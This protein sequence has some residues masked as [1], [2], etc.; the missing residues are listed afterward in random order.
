MSHFSSVSAVSIEATTYRATSP[1]TIPEH[2]PC[3]TGGVLTV[4]DSSFTTKVLVHSGPTATKRCTLVALLDT[5]SPQSFITATAVEQ[6]KASSS[7]S[8]QCIRHA[9]PRS[10]GGFGTA[11]PL[12]TSDSIRLSI[13]FMRSDSNTKTPTAALAVWACIV[14]AGTMQHSILLGRDS[15][16]RFGQRSY[17][18]LP[19]QP[20]LPHHNPPPTQG[21]LTLHHHGPSGTSAFIPDD[22]YTDDV[23]HLRFAG[24]KTVSLSPTP[25]LVKV[26]L[27]R[28]SGAPA[29]TGN[30][31]VNMDPREDPL[32][33]TAIFVS[34][35]YQT[36]PLSGS[37]DLEPGDLL[38]TSSSPLVQVPLATLEHP[39]LDPTPI[40][41]VHALHDNIPVANEGPPSADPPPPPKSPCP[42][43]L[44][45]LDTDQRTRFL[46]LWDRLP[47]H[48]RDV[49]FDL[50]GSGWSP[51]VIDA[52]GDV[53]CEYQDVFSSSKTDFGSCSL[54]PF[55]ITVPP[56]S[57]PVTSRPYRIN[58]PILAKKADAVLDQYLAAGLIQHST[59][60]YSSPMV[61]IPKKD[62]GV[63]ITINYKKLNAISS[64]GQL[65]IPRVDQVLDSLGK[66]RIFSLFDLTS[67]FHQITIDEATIPLTAFC[68]PT[69]LFEW[70][71]M[72]QGSSASPGWFVKVINEVIK[73]LERVAAYLD[74]IIVFDPDPTAHV[75][76]MRALFER[77]RKHHLKLSPAK[78]KIGATTADFLGHTITAGGFSP[79]A[80]KVAALTK[81]PIPKNKKQVRSLIGAI[82]YYGK[83]LEN[84]SPRIRR[85]TALLKKDATF[86]FTPDMVTTVRD[87][88][89]ELSKPPIL[90]YPD[91]DAVADNSRPFRLYCDA[92]LDGFGATLEQE[93]P[94]GSVRPILYIS[95]ATLDSERSWTPLDLEAG[96]IVWAI[97]RLRGHLWSTKFRVYS[98]HKALEN[99]AKVGEHNARV[100]RWLEFLSA[101]DYTLEYRKGTANGNADFLSRLPLPATEADRTGRN[102]LTGPDTV[103][104]YLIRPCGFSPCEP[105]TPGIGLGGL[106]SPPS[107]PI[108][109][110]QALRFT[111]DDFGDFRLLGPRI[112]HPDPFSAPNIFVGPI[113]THNAIDEPLASPEKAAVD[114]GAPPGYASKPPVV[115]PP[116]TIVATVPAPSDLI[117]SR[118]RHRAAA[119]AGTPLATADYGF[120]R[121]PK[122]AE[123]R[124]PTSA[125][126]TPSPSSTAQPRLLQPPTP[127]AAA[128]PQAAQPAP[129]V[130]TH[131]RSTPS[132]A[133]SPPIPSTPTPPLPEPVVEPDDDPHLLARVER[134]TYKDWAREQRAEPLCSA[135]IR[136]LSLDSPS[137]PPPD[138]LDFIPLVRRPQLSDVL[139]LGA[140]SKLHRTDDN[141]ALLVLQPPNHP[142]GNNPPSSALP[143]PRVYVPMLMRPWV[144]QTCHATTSLHLGVT[145][146]V[147]MLARFYWWVGMDASARWW[148]RRCLTCQA[149][150]TSRQTIRWPILSLPLPNGPGIA[151]SV[152]Y[153]GP[154][155]LTPRGNVHILLF[156]DRF[157]RR[158]D[159]FPVS[160]AQFTAAGTADIFI[161][162]YITLWGCPVTLLSDN[163]LQFT[164]KLSRIVYERLGVRKINT[165]SYHPCTN[166]GVERVNHVLAQMLSMI[167]NEQQTDWD[168]LLPHVSSAY[169]NSVNAATGLAPNE[170]HI[171]RLPRLPLSVFE[172]DNIGGHQSLDRDHLA[173][174]NL[175]TD[176][177][178]RAYSLV[179]ELYSITTSRL[180][181]RN[182]P[183][184]AALLASPPFT[185]GGWA[186]VYNS[187]S[188]IRQ[189]V[190]KD[191]DATVLK[192]KLSLNWNGPF[193]ILA[194]GPAAACDTPDNRPLHDKL[195]FLDLPSDLPG[196]DSKPRVS[197][198]RCKP[199]RN[200]DD[201]TDIPHYLPAGLTTYVLTASANKSP[202]YHVTLDDVSPPPERLEV[203]KITGHQLVRGRGGV[204]AVLYETHWAGLLSPS[205][206]RE[207]DLQHSR[208]HILLYWS[209]TPTQHRQT[210]RLYRQMRIGAAHRELSRSQGQVFLA[211]GYTLVPRDLWL[212]NF[213]TTI[214]P[215]GA[216][217]WYKARDGLWW[218]GKIAHRAPP[219]SPSE[220]LRDPSQGDSYIIRFLDDPGPIKINLPPARYTTTRN[221][222][223]GSWCLQRH[224]T[225]S[226]A[227]GLLRNSD[228]SRGTTTAPTPPAG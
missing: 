109:T 154:L 159:M 27:V 110:I 176:R 167:G 85:I 179:R 196:R 209:G 126:R 53:L 206:E 153:F 43:L 45:R 94:D 69:R 151:V 215:S 29:F 129:P 200:P 164:S 219:D 100:R 71:V 58:N 1:R 177:Q 34:D 79:N 211:P 114:T 52:L 81:M 40:P 65:P 204:I 46:H 98:D 108:P 205:W 84:L 67:S 50:H 3:L 140:K 118:T 187:A 128:P 198:K 155:P 87:I 141:T 185:V 26:N 182:A 117:S 32:S 86:N 39:S 166:G 68:T 121:R 208:R 82:N 18:T 224:G 91:W 104:I 133:P 31:M 145:R 6:L 149:R 48:L 136:F 162:E 127:P 135:T 23:Y 70:L 218:L 78:A 21:E 44:A 184:M 122:Q 132:P 41:D 191:T 22:R 111:D 33:D 105:P 225:G 4:D 139:A 169:N 60:P 213:S 119:A 42:T 51:S 192:T 8:D 226:L 90:V 227:R 59:S 9:Q 222:I 107:R 168:V 199:C 17:T 220:T 112:E 186:W 137:P 35:G 216:H 74:D 2:G 76:N 163:G 93:Q 113:S 161:N 158:A 130:S 152:D 25:T 160:A 72:P 103:G 12:T 10:W 37:T 180:Q 142:P 125:R 11:A 174:I 99:I 13:Q 83:F 172:P 194:V 97:K 54:M 47:L 210:N 28:Q 7:A 188:T 183:I 124:R 73:G 217:V 181:R 131:P 24:T 228:V 66:G 147:R 77:L 201:T 212:R 138:L 207:L 178:Q 80:D 62:G 189:G 16:M 19:R 143:S 96:S 175:A 150:K 120:G 57:D 171:G 146:T 89:G 15:W 102:R 95:R 14:P 193:K 221:A 223:Y 123:P 92:S 64:L 203:E 115:S 157:S 156:T 165:S 190:R 148:I 202:P 214:L 38:G 36:V 88:L 55:K 144:L 56:D 30:Y 49:M 61:A 5:G 101:Y 170:V 63:R 106:V 75:A 116:S 195:L 134:Y 20:S 173:Y 197:V